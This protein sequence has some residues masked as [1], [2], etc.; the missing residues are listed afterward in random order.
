M[1]TTSQEGDFDR[2]KRWGKEF[3]AAGQPATGGTGQGGSDATAGASGRC[4]RRGAQDQAEVRGHM[5][6]K[7]RH[8]MAGP[9]YTRGRGQDMRTKITILLGAAA[10]TLL[11]V[12][13]A[14]PASA[15]PAAASAAADRGDGPIDGLY[16]H[17]A[18]GTL[19]LFCVLGHCVPRGT[20]A[21][22]LWSTDPAGH[23]P[24]QIIG[25]LTAPG[26]VC[27]WWM[28]LDSWDT[29]GRNQF[30]DQGTAQPCAWNAARE[31][32]APTQPSGYL[33]QGSMCATLFVP[34]SGGARRLGYV[35]TTIGPDSQP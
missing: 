33:H 19:S 23:F 26:D 15:A 14:V 8:G 29:G 3:L 27:T 6:R 4:G 18:L 1:A 24:Q 12:F 17:Q 13:T 2:V 9:S 20:I 5:V 10:A 7:A 16:E 35:C 25:V 32:D 11:A 21:I 31:W 30:H 22:T 34:G 28:D